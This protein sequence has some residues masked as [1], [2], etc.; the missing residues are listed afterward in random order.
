MH[1]YQYAHAAK[2]DAFEA[3]LMVMHGEHHERPFAQCS[4]AGAPDMAVLARSEYEGRHTV[5]LAHSAYDIERG[6]KTFEDVLAIAK[7]LAMA[8]RAKL[9][10]AGDWFYKVEG[11]T[12]YIGSFK[13]RFYIRIYEKGQQVIGRLLNAGRS[14][15][16]RNVSP[17]WVRIECVV[18][19]RPGKPQALAATCKPEELFGFGRVGRQI[20]G[21]VSGNFV[22]HTPQSIRK[23]EDSE[24]AEYFMFTQYKRTL[25]RL[26]AQQGAD[27]HSYIQDKLDNPGNGYA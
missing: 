17:H 24:R 19:P 3:L 7:P 23:I 15:E 18:K 5:S 20:F 9:H 14:K 16:A 8:Y 26:V 6:E 12:L 4:G 10:P 11:R 21:E 27:L 25:A 22:A 2:L 1:G 13:S